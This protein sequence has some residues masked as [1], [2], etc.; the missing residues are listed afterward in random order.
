MKTGV[1][2]KVPGEE[3]LLGLSSVFS[4]I[5]KG[6]FCLFVLRGVVYLFLFYFIFCYFLW[7]GLPFKAR[8]N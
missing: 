6:G 5:D 7:P 2:C 4:I 3:R 8:G 1:S